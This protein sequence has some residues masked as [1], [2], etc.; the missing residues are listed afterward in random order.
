MGE[1]SRSDAPGAADSRAPICGS[2]SGRTPKR[3]SADRAGTGSAASGT[4]SSASAPVVPL[5]ERLA[6][7]PAEAAAVLGISESALRALAPELPRIVRNR[8]VLYPTSGLEEWLRR[9][10]RR[11][12]DP[13]GAAAV[14]ALARDS[15]RKK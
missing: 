11:E 5:G 10:A 15:G 4:E 3:A 1:N 12:G 14:L 9:E 7:R 6:L 8:L 2:G 13:I